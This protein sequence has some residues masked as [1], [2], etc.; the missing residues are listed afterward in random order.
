MRLTCPN[1]GAQYE[2]PD[3]VIPKEGR[4]VQCS[5]CGNTWFFAHPDFSDAKQETPGTEADALRDAVRDL[6]QPSD[7]DRSVQPDQPASPKQPSPPEAARRNLDPNIKDILREE[8]RHE[9][10]LR[11]AEARSALE[12]QPDLGLDNAGDDPELRARQ[13]RERMARM[14][15]E[16]V[17]SPAPRLP[18]STERDPRPTSRK[19]MLPDI[20]EIS[21]SLRQSETSEGR[22][23]LGTRNGRGKGGGFKR[24]FAVAIIIVVALSLIYANA[25]MVAEKL[26]EADPMLSAFVALVDEG[27]LWLHQ[28]INP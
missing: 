16:P 23:T 27:R 7:P 8:A 6:G 9:A 3:Q 5:N 24:G 26:P 15:G 18:V 17:A 2:V 20:E 25:P 1:C 4:D 19:E 22:V 13:A 21:S 28:A 14:R 12:S 11:E 10:E